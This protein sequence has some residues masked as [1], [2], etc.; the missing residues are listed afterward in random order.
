MASLCYNLK[1]MLKFRV[2]KSQVQVNYAPIAERMQQVCDFLF[3][4]FSRLFP[5]DISPRICEQNNPASKQDLLKKP[6]LKP[7]F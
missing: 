5:F 7:I 1:K 3:S 4:V 6:Y 2:K